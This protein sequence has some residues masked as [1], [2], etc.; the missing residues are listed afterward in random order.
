MLCFGL[1]LWALHHVL[2][3]HRY[4]DVLA[5]LRE[6]PRTRLA[7]A[8]ALTAAGYT[9]LVGYDRLA[10]QFVG[11]AL[12]L[13]RIAL[14]SF[15][16]YAFGNNIG[17]TLL[18]GATARYWFYTSVGVSAADVARIVV[19]CSLGF[20]LGYFTLAT[21][22]F[23]LE[24]VAVP[25]ALHLP[26]A[27][28]QPLGLAL[29]ALLVA[30]G[31]L[32]ASRRGRVRLGGWSLELPSPRL[33]AGQL[34][35]GTADLA[36]MSAALWVLL[37]AELGLSYLAFLPVFLVA[38]AAGAAS[39]VPG[40]L[41]VFEAT[42]LLL[43]PNGTAGPELVGALLA[44]RG[45]YCLL[46]LLIA[47]TLVALHALRARPSWLRAS[48][49]HIHRWLGTAVPEILALATFVAGALLVFSGALPAA[50]GR[51][52]WLV[53]A[54]PLPLIEA[55]HFLGSVA[56]MALLVLARG[57]QRRLDAAY[58][59]A[60]ALLAAGIV[61]SLGK[62][63]DYEE[64]IVLAL[65]LALLA[66]S[67]RYFYRRASLLALPL[68]RGWIA[69]I[70]IVA[71]GSLWLYGFAFRHA[72]YLE[73]PW[74]HFALYA[75]APRALRATVGAIAAAVLFAAARLLRPAQPPL[76]AASE[77]EI[78]RARPVIE[79]SP[80]TYANLVLRG[81]K[82]LLFSR[83]GNAF[84][85]YGRMRRSWIAMGDS[86]GPQEEARE[87]AWQ[88]R[89]LCDR[90]G[91]WPV[92]FEVGAANLDLYLDLGLA[93]T[94]LGEEARVELS[95]FDLQGPARSGLR[96]GH[97]RVLRQ[98]CRFEILPREAVPQA[99][100]ELER[101]SQDW[102]A[103]KA[104][105]EKGFSNASFD[106]AYLR[107]FPVAVVKRGERLIAFANLWLGAGK[108]ELSVDLMRHTGDAPNGA[109]DFLFA[110][111]M[112]WGRQQGYRWFNLGTA[113]LSGLEE[114]AGAPLWHRFG[115]LVYQY[116]EHF[117][118]FRGLRQY[119]EKFHPVWS[120]RYLASP[121]GLAL[122]AVLVDVAAL[123]AGGFAGILAR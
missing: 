19:F 55:S 99:V 91:A 87:L 90:H 114:R 49:E 51:L 38:L 6:L 104:T 88:F 20:W 61:L 3:E 122:P 8:L 105:R 31:V 26:L 47:A 101:I 57:L 102:L 22:A 24:P 100:P 1:A 50:Q 52:A 115:H 119:K 121:G 69:S 65:I 9:V 64:A 16:G 40:G 46:P 80:N 58:L 17:H 42:L 18:A 29:F 59:L 76:P 45:I 93:L 12:P 54:L 110:E 98:G 79:R 86:I 107:Q 48:S 123:I 96:Q 120:P 83:S 72:E 84:L 41:G 28:T 108:E 10:F 109:M 112:L 27:T 77:E 4:Q 70:A 66:A 39:Q 13:K 63:L 14:A 11:R 117:Y 78:A 25:A 43:I 94:K 15:V 34:A 44:F 35:V 82:A 5:A 62:G 37:P 113:P 95:Q 81:D 56:G 21:A 92:F 60:L 106:V 32:V 74:W 118:N 68:T 53:R 2:R 89:D 116:G 85:M 33:T 97:A 73:K 103:A 23:T 111:L 7:L 71:V 36:L 75:E 30:Y 67:R